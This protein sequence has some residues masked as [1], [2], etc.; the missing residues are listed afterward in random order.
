[1]STAPVAAPAAPAPDSGQPGLSQGARI[2]N[3]FFAPSKTF[4]DIKRSA[5]WWAPFVLMAIVSYGFIAVVAKKVGFEQV[6][7]N[8]IRMNPKAAERLEQ[9]PADQ[10]ARQMGIQTAV[11]KGI[12][13]GFPIVNL[14]VLTIIA[15]VLMATFN[16]GAGAEIPFKQA[17]AVV[18]YANL[19]GI[20]KAVLAMVSLLAGSDPEGFTFQNPVATNLGYLVDPVSSR[21][22]YS[23]ASA[24]DVIAIWVLV[25]TGIGFAR[26]SKLKMATTMSVVFGWYILVT[27][28]GV[29]FAAAFS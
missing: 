23:A 22:L 2:L 9:L 19:A 11:T 10:R 12:S 6:T 1:M 7:Q 25:L 4:T 8:Q 21:V 26:V 18:I 3:T 20:V 24:V 15:A 16:F 28:I 5:S 14:I 17:L 29:G 27:L 13:F